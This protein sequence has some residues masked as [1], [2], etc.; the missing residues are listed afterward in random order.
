MSS[1]RNSLVVNLATHQN[2]QQNA[3]QA[4]AL[5]IAKV[6]GGSGVLVLR[7]AETARNSEN[8]M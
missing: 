3:G 7:H 6:I 2:I 4:L 8:L 1:S 5:W